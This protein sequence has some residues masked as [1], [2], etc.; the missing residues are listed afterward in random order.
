V[1]VDTS[2][3]YFEG[4]AEND[5]VQLGNWARLLRKLTDMPGKPG[6]IVGCH[7]IKSGESLLP[8]G[9]GAFLAEMDGNLT[10]KKL[11]DEIIELHW[12]G[13]YRGC[14][15]EPVL[16]KIIRITSRRVMDAKG[17]MIPSVM[18]RLTDDATLEHL[19]PTRWATS[20]RRRRSAR[21]KPPS[22]DL[23][24]AGHRRR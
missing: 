17:R 24:A 13:K 20:G 4:D 22:T 19:R 11:S 1:I 2:A 3:A 5:N 21:P 8:R 14:S 16:F 6:V 23:E 10:C 18:V 15:F 12:S 7:P 9:G